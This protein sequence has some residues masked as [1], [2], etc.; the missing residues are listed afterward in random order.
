MKRIVGI[1]L[2][3]VGLV[4]FFMGFNRKDSLAGGAAE[5]GTS[6]ANAVDGGVRAPQHTTYMIVGGILVLAGVG[7]VATSRTGSVTKL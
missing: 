5:V 4:V 2:I 6:V 3:V 1:L 7:V